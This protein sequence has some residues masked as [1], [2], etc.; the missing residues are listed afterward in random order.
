MQLTSVTVGAPRYIRSIRC[1]YGESGVARL[2]GATR[3][4]VLR[5]D[6]D[7]TIISAARGRR[8]R[9]RRV[10]GR[11][12]RGRGG[13]KEAIARDRAQRLR[14]T[15]VSRERTS[16]GIASRDPKQWFA[17]HRVPGPAGPTARCRMHCFALPSQVGER[18][19]SR[20]HSI[21]LCT[22]CQKRIPY[23]PLHLVAGGRC[24]NGR[25]I[26]VGW[27]CRTP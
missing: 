17:A 10:R 12:V 3:P 20:A 15:A 18:K 7:Q 25:E 21:V 26:G 22:A 4:L 5:M 14:V 24:R 19:Y 9:G 2:Q 23:R 27:S 13:E 8:V 11:R 6:E 16:R 1:V